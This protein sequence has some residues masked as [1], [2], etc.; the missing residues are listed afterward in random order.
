MTKI[1]HSEP[2]HDH[3]H[4]LG[5]DAVKFLEDFDD[6]LV[7]L[8]GLAPGTR[9]TYCFW[10]SRFLATFCGTAAPNWSLL[11]G[12]V[13]S[14][15]VQNEASRLK[16]N[17]RGAPGVA[18]RALLRYLGFLGVIQDGLQGAIPQ[19]PRWKHVGLPR[20]LPSADVDRVVA[21][22]LN[23]SARGLRNHAILLLLA[24]TGLRAH[25]VAQ[26]SLDDIDWIAGSICCR[27]KKSRTE[28]TLP[29]A[30][31]VG[32][33]LADYLRRGRPAC[34]FRTIFLRVIPPFDPFTG[35]AA[36]CR[37][38]RRALT[39]RYSQHAGCRPSFSTY[40]GHSHA[41][42]RSDLQGDRRCPGTCV[43]FDHRD[44]RQAG[45]RGPFADRAAMAGE[46]TMSTQELQDQLEQYLAVRSALGLKDRGRKS[47]LQ[48]FLRYLA[49]VNCD[50]SI[51]VHLAV[52]WAVTTPR[53][54]DRTGRSVTSF[55][56]S[57]RISIAF[58]GEQ[59]TGRSPARS[60][61]RGGEGTPSLPI[62]VRPDCRS[63]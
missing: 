26:L 13:L 36:V 46:R 44:L 35:S 33:A 57:A 21:G 32:A 1:A 56:C 43:D 63:S 16:R 48:D 24:R 4:L 27:S 52:D 34:S 58:A 62:F 5:I 7:R 60:A 18:L 20:Y 39:L 6:Y 8:K 41:Q 12:S 28:R 54:G 14:T 25:E 11:R 19:R 37:I 10:V 29:L 55:D 9:K 61:S 47:L 59:S 30:H 15:F 53:A 45:Y 22:A 49:E 23:G 42:R 17:G 50:G 31:D 3:R 51:P 40:R 38:A 2:P